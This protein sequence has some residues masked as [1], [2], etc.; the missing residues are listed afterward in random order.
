MITKSN[1]REY[2]V[3]ERC[4]EA[5]ELPGEANIRAV[6]DWLDAKGY[7]GY[8][9]GANSTHICG[10]CANKAHIVDIKLAK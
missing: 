3:C 4:G 6:D 7:V 2:I 9:K 5:E 10:D 8:R 1:G